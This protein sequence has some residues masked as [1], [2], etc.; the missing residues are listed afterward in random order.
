[1]PLLHSKGSHCK[2]I[3]LATVAQA[4]TRP[5]G[6]LSDLDLCRERQDPASE[7]NPLFLPGGYY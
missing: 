7:E 6:T 4:H 1:M 3:T 5:G 2:G